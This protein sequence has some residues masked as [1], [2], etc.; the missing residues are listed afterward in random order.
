M[1]PRRQSSSPRHPEVAADGP[2]T[3]LLLAIHMHADREGLEC[4]A[5]DAALAAAA[6]LRVRAIAG[7]IDDLERA[8]LVAVLVVP[9]PRANAGRKIV[10]M[11]HE[12]AEWYV[13]ETR[14]ALAAGILAPE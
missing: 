8:G 5:S 13:V 14:R 2:A 3:R 11:D 6:G 4:L 1:N 7:L 10:L 9:P 12:V